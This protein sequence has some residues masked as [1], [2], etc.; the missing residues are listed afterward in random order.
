MVRIYSAGLCSEGEPC[1]SYKG[2]TNNAWNFEADHAYEK[3]LAE[4]EA[5]VKEAQKVELI[6]IQPTKLKLGEKDNV[7]LS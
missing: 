3:F 4:V 2:D 1:L 5:E 7:N 6:T